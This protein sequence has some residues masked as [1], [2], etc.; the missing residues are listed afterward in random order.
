M[1]ITIYVSEFMTYYMVVLH[2]QLGKTFSLARDLS[3]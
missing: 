1:S 2:E 3:F